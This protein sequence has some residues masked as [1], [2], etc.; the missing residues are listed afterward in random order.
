MQAS[1]PKTM[2]IT[3]KTEN[4]KGEGLLFNI[5]TIVMILIYFIF[6]HYLNFYH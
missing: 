5:I 2:K 1:V 6:N 3:H 4:F